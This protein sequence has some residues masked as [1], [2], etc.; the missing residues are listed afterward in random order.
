MENSR[1]NAIAGLALVDELE[2]TASPRWL[3]LVT[4]HVDLISPSR[5]RTLRMAATFAGRRGD[6]ELVYACA[7]A[8]AAWASRFGNSDALAALAHVLGEVALLE[9]GP[10]SAAEHFERALERLAEIEAPFE[11]ALTQARAGAALLAV[12]ERELGVERLVSA[13]RT[14]RKLGARPF[15][16]LTAAE[17]QAAGERVDERL[18]RRAVGDLERHGLTRRELEIL[19]LV[20]V[21]RT[22]REIGHQLF[23]STRTVDMHVRNMLT[24]LG[25]RSR[26]EATGRAHELGLLETV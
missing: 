22:N 6:S 7:E 25:C 19:R 3:E 4:L 26:T 20:G 9:G 1:Q 17:L 18:G 12:G 21:G 23:L 15:A 13:Y 11:H 24:K 5:P 8:S 10:P 2:G 16:T 14:L